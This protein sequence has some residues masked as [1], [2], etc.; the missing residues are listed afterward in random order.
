MTINFDAFFSQ[1]LESIMVNELLDGEYEIFVN[2]VPLDHI[3]RGIHIEEWD[4][5]NIKSKFIPILKKAD[6]ERR[7]IFLRAYPYDSKKENFQKDQS[8]LMNFYKRFGFIEVSDGWMY[9]PFKHINENLVMSDVMGANSDS[10]YDVSDGRT[11][12]TMGTYSRKGK[13]R[14]K[15][16]K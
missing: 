14:R 13:K 4:L 3:K 2:H 16:K 11:P 5:E 9:R 7:F 12:F 8:R 15:R 6:N 1:I 10:P